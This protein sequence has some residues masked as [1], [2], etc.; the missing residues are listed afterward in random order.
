MTPESI[1]LKVAEV[2]FSITPEGISEAVAETTRG[3]TPAGHNMAAAETECNIGVQGWSFEGPTAS[4]E[5]DGGAENNET[6]GSQS[7]DA[8]KNE[9]A[10]LSMET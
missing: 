9:D 3:V 8:L 1:T 2:S 6:L 5:V 10:G 4:Q 7:T